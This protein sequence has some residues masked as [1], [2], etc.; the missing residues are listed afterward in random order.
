VENRKSPE[1]PKP[2]IDRRRV[3]ARGLKTGAGIAVLS[4]TAP[5]LQSVALAQNDGG[6]PSPGN[7]DGFGISFVA[8]L[9][10]CGGKNY[11]IKW[12]DNDNF[13][14][15]E[16]GPKFNTGNC[17][18]KLMR[19]DDSIEKDCPDGVY[20]T[21]NS[22]G[23]VTVTLG[24]CTIVDFVVKCGQCCAGPLDAGE[25]PTGGTGSETFFPCESNKAGCS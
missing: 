24:S 15:A 12:E 18:N 6:T 25:P 3:L 23:T 14:S 16:C 8:L 20:A 4:W 10:Q 1:M 13:Q 9:V 21:G 19:N 2:G 11:R 22:D 17:A 5:A 7:G